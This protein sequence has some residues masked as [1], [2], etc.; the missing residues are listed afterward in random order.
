MIKVSVLIP[1]YNEEKYIEESIKSVL[2]QNFKNFEI[3][4]IND[5]S[6]DRTVAIVEEFMQKDGRIKLINIKENG[7]ASKAYNEGLKQARG[8]Y[9]AIFNGD[10][11]MAQNRLQE[12]VKF[13]DKNKDIDMVYGDMEIFEEGGN[14]RI[15]EAIEFDKNPREILIESSKRKDLGEIWPYKLIDYKDKGEII[16]CSSV[17]IRKKLFEKISFDENLRNSEDYDLWLQI[18]GNGFK[19]ARIPLICF[20]YRKHSGQKSGDVNKMKIAARYINEKLKRGEFFN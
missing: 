2:N 5:D 19:I 3:I 18:I 20:Y 9:I 15:V 17:I 13:L 11:L 12:Q 14:R 1:V 7:G 6:K 4:V 10:D 8:E 16:P